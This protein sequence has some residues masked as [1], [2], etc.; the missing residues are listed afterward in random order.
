MQI[1]KDLQNVVDKYIS[2]F[3]AEQQIFLSTFR[4]IVL[5]AAPHASE[6]IWYKMPSYK[7]NRVLVSF[8]IYKNHIG[9]YPGAQAIEAFKTK[10]TSYKNS[11]GAVQFPLDKPFPAALISTIVKYR[12]Q[13]DM[14][15]K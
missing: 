5:K 12:L 1:K 4:N 11:K 6:I 10:I 9:F 7:L 15:K 2:G 14:K 3:P 13:Q 8:A